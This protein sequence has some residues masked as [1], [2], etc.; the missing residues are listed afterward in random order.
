MAANISADQFLCG[1]RRILDGVERQAAP[2]VP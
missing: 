1:L 2:G